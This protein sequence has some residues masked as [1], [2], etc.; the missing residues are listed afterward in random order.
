MSD[1]QILTAVSHVAQDPAD[2]DIVRFGT[3]A[4]RDAMWHMGIEDGLFIVPKRLKRRWQTHFDIEPRLDTPARA[5]C[6]GFWHLH[7]EDAEKAGEAFA[8]VRALPQGEGLYLTAHLLAQALAATSAEDVAQWLPGAEGLGHLPDPPARPDA[9]ATL[10][11][12]RDVAAEV[13]VAV[14][15]VAPLLSASAMGRAIAALTRLLGEVDAVCPEPEAALVRQVAER[16]RD[17]LAEAGGQMGE[18]VLRQPVTNPYEGYSGLPVAATFTGRAGVLRRLERLWATDPDAPLPPVILHGHRRMGKTSIL[19]HLRRHHSRDLLVA[20]ADMQD[21]T[22]ADHTG[23][24][25]HAFTR[26]IAEAAREGDL[27]P[28]PTPEVADCATTGAARLVLNALL[29]HLDPQMAGRRLILAVDEYEL[30]EAKI[31]AGKF[32]ADFLRYLRSMAQQHRWLGLI[33]AGR[34]T[35]EDELRHYKA[36]FFG[37]AE[38]LKVSFLDRRDALIL[39]RRPSDDFALEYESTLAE[40]LYRLTH[41]QPYLLQ[42]LCWELVNRWNDRFLDEGEATPRVL[43][44]ADLDALLTPAFYQDFFLQA[45]YYFS[46]VWDEAGPGA[47]RLMAALASADADALAREDLL[48]AAGM[49]EAEGEAA[50]QDALRHDF[51]LEEE[52]NIR[53]AVPLM[54]RW[55]LEMQ[56]ARQ[57]DERSS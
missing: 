20:Y 52:G 40:A 27:A 1:A 29:D 32:D 19:H 39:I 56:M 47:R 37:S 54:R 23:Q 22:L 28:G 41:G 50:L 9:V 2:W 46:G 18:E 13:D 42:R 30:A 33:F 48:R 5:A 51:I 8:V 7:K 31:V 11:R 14:H 6:A 44:R 12:L 25:L 26:V 53:L 4:L 21:L 10:L 3:V 17:L 43:T 38:P 57:N 35:L 55:L 24:L 36:V 45:D 16:W 34:Q 15:A 49:A